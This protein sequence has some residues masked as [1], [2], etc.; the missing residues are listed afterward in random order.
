MI[1]DSE[2]RELTVLATEPDT[3]PRRVHNLEV[4]NA[5]TY[6]V[7]ELEAWGHNGSNGGSKWPSASVACFEDAL[8][9]ALDFIEEATGAPFKPTSSGP[10][11]FG[12]TT[13][14]GEGGTQI[15]IETD[16]RHGSH[17]NATCPK[18]KKTFEFP[19]G[20][21]SWAKRGG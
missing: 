10:G 6:F 3:T 8:S 18:S 9:E 20:I 13:I 15:R 4:A 21:P 11:K 14:Q 5:H 12:G 16:D 1:R 7:G 19:G 17:V 2:L